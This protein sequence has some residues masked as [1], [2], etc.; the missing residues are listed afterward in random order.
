V[1]PTTFARVSRPVSVAAALLLVACGGGG[2]TGS[3]GSTGSLVVR[4]HDHPIEAAEHVYVTIE[5]VEVFKTVD[6]QEVH[7]TVTSVPGQYDLLELQHGVEAV[8]GGGEFAPGDYHS[9]RLIVARDSK[10]DIRTLPADQL[11]NYIVVEGVP[12][13]L[14]IPS[15]EQT[16]IKLGKNFTIAAGVTTVLTLDF[17]V[18]KSIHSCGH[19]HVYRLKPRIKVVPTESDAGATG[20]S[21]SITTT[22]G[23]G[24]PSGTVVSA[25]QNG[26][27]VASATADGTG[28]YALTG[29]ADGTYDLVVIAP[30]YGYQSE[31]GVSVAGGNAT[32]SHDFAVAPVSAG[33]VYGTA[34]PDSDDVTVHLVWNG[35]V[36]ATVGADPTTGDYVIDNVPPGD[37]S[38]DGVD[39]STAHTASGTVT[40][41]G[42]AAVRL[43]LS[44]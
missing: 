14:L 18:R 11:K 16:G 9:I 23:T 26:A 34:T 30:G 40:V 29:L 3:T 1:I 39:G 28:A 5:S 32:G 27:E 24:L 12:Y 19:N 6:G 43:D 41:T 31:T 36:V 2:S 4:M 13:P 44:L 35:F 38:V 37:Y 20:L 42:G 17:D 8:L 10:H 25:Q 22:D 33:A 7:E 15:G 21:G